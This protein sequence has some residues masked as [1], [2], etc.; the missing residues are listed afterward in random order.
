MLSGVFIGV[1]GLY[2]LRW[3]NRRREKEQQKVYDMVEKIIGQLTQ[4][5]N[6]KGD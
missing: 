2:Y 6:L 3:L 4:T 1:L 5:L